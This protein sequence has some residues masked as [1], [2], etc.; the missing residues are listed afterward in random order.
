M[1]REE[2][3]PLASSGRGPGA[4]S[5][6]RA[7]RPPPPPRVSSSPPPPPPPPPQ[8]RHHDPPPPSLPSLS[9]SS[10]Q[11]SPWPRC[12][13]RGRRAALRAAAP[14]SRAPRAAAQRQ[15]GC[16]TPCRRRSRAVCIFGGRRGEGE[17]QWNDGISRRS[18]FARRERG[19]GAARRVLAGELRHAYIVP[20]FTG[21]RH[22]LRAE[23]WKQ[24]LGMRRPTAN[25]ANFR[26]KSFAA[27]RL[28]P[29]RPSLRSASLGRCGG[30]W[31]R[32]A[33]T[34]GCASKR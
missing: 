3:P 30:R 7:H 33:R 19:R 16:G 31:R 5:R 2:R 25:W 1:P 6:H 21:A 28:G 26:A 23:S 4:S 14:R 22:T 8:L 34:H 17:C 24:T 27:C 9:S 18:R 15:C 10:W 13:L 29:S 20:R 32:C 12:C 11:H